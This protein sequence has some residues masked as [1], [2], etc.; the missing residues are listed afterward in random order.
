M[1]ITYISENDPFDPDIYSGTPHCIFKGLQESHTDLQYLHIPESQAYLTPLQELRF[2][3]KQFWTT[4]YKRA[5]LDTQLFSPRTR[6]INTAIKKLLAHHKTDAILTAI[7]P[8]SFAYLETN[9]PIIYWT[10]AIY[11]ALLGFYPDLRFHH[12]DTMWDAYDIVDASLM[13][14]KRLIFSSQWAARSA[15]ELHGIAKEK[16]S[17]VPFGANL[18]IDHNLDDV[19][20]MIKA[21]SNECIKLLFVGKN[22]YRKGGD[23]VLT[24]A[25]ALHASGYPVELTIVGCKFNIPLPSFVN[26]IEFLYKKNNAD[27]DLLKRLYREAHFFMMPSRA[28]AF[29]IVFCEANAFAVPCI[30]TYVGGIA[31][32]VKDNINGMTFSLEATIKEYCDYIINLM[33]NKP[34]YEALALSA[35]NEY[36]TRLNWQVALKQVK[37][38]IHETI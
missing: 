4:Y 20:T 18:A 14:A 21:R 32:V 3:F 38:I 34:Q 22:W 7:T 24:V 10:D 30:T 17:V 5:V 29:G 23:I 19:K 15:I 11:T 27:I 1:R 36:Q 9:V 8:I 2:R 37:Q 35:F 13:N 16:I 12:P 25:N 31:D 33:D 26:C 6:E 28:E